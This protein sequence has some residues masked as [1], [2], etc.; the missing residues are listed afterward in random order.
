MDLFEGFFGIWHEEVHQCE[1]EEINA[2]LV[3]SRIYYAPSFDILKMI[4]PSAFGSYARTA[5]IIGDI[6]LKN[7]NSFKKMKCL[8]DENEM[9]TS[10]VNEQIKTE[11]DLFIPG[12]KAQLIGM[13]RHFRYFPGVYIIQDTNGTYF[14]IGTKV[15]PAFV[16]EFKFSTGKKHEDTVGV[17]LKLTSN[18]P[19]FVYRGKIENIDLSDF[20]NEYDKDYN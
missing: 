7:G 3:D 17:K 16:N 13:M 8:I 5:T 9:N 10:I 6:E 2:G 20:T 12:S 1:L 18:A 4:T 15:S 14:T 19:P 11:L